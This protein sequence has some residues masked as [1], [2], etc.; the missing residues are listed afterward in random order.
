MLEAAKEE[1]SI[2]PVLGESVFP[3]AADPAL[4]ETHIPEKSQLGENSRQGFRSKNRAS[5]QAKNAAKSTTA[6]G[7]SWFV[8]A[9]TAVGS[10]VAYDG[11]GNRVSETIGGTTTKYLVDALNPTGLPQVLDEIISGSVTRTYAYGLQRISENQLVGSTWTPSFYGYD[12]H[13]NV[14]FLTNSAGAITDTYTYDAFGMQIARTGTTP[15]VFQ[16]SGEW[17]DSNLGLYYLRARYLNQATGRFW[18]RD[19]VEG[20]KCCG[21]SWNPYIYVKQNPV[22]AVDP[23]GKEEFF[24]YLAGILEEPLAVVRATAIAVRTE[25]YEE[26]LVGE[27]ILWREEGFD[28]ATSIAQA[29][30]WCSA[31]YPPIP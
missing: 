10:G 11:D 3:L 2:L 18:A 20:V 21:M 30:I 16:F 4:V 8:R 5:H 13:G 24:E 31:V 14:R 9:G 26:C 19:P 27:I 22:N 12:G 1:I 28:L 15:N 25:L 7:V 29:T 17:L 23:T 6:L